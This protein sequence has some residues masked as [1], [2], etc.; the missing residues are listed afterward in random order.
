MPRHRQSPERRQLTVVYCDLVGSTALSNRIDAEELT[1]LIVAYRDAV[2]RCV[3][4]FDGMVAQYVG[5]GVLAYFGY[6]SAHENAAERAIRASLAM[7]AAVGQLH[8]ADGQPVHAHI[9]IATGSVVIGSLPRQDSV[10]V[11]VGHYANAAEEISAVGEAPNLAARLQALA[12]PD[13]IIVAPATRRLAGR[14]FR[15]R[16]LGDAHV[17]GFDEPVPTWEVT[18]ERTL[19]SRFHA[20]H[21]VG[22][23]PLIG[24]SREL[25]LL[26]ELWGTACSGR[27]QAVQLAG[28]P[29]LGKSRLAEAAVHK[30][31]EAAAIQLWYHCAPHSQSSAL[32]PLVRQLTLASRIDTADADHLKLQK[33]E[34]ILPDPAQRDTDTVPLLADLLAVDYTREYPD[35]QRMSARRRRSRLF[36]TVLLL[37]AA[38]AEQRPVVVVV[39]D[40]HWIDPSSMELIERAIDHIQT[41]PVMLIL[42]TRPGVR[43]PWEGRGNHREI[44][45]RPL[46][47]ASS[48]ALVRHLL[49]ARTVSRSVMERITDRADGVPLYI[50]GLT[51]HVIE[52]AEADGT[53]DPERPGGGE[54]DA[55][56]V[57]ASL[58]DSLM[59]RLDRIGATE[60]RVAQVA[61]VFGREFG[62]AML[63]GTSDVSRTHLDTAIDRLV[64]SGLVT[65]LSGRPAP[66]YSFRH[67]LIRDTA[68]SSLLRKERARLHDRAGRLLCDEFPEI[69]E[70]QPELI[71]HHF[72]RA[73]S[74]ET[75]ADFWLM[76]GRRSAKRSSFKEA[77]EQLQHVLSLLADQP[78]TPGTMQREMHAYIALGGA[79][80][81]YRGFSAP[82]SGEAYGT[83]LELARELDSTNEYF[84]ALSGAGSYHITR[85]EFDTC[86][87]L[88][89]ECL[90]RASRQSSALPFVIGRRLLGGTLFLTGEL[91]S[92]VEQ[93]KTAIALYDEHSSSFRETGMLYVQDHKSTALCYLALAY[94]VMGYL[95]R[96][97]QCARASLNHSRSLRDLHATNFSLTYLAAVHHFRR[98]APQ[99][100]ERARESM[101]MALEQEFGTWV[102]VSRMIYGEA[103]VRAGRFEEG[104]QAIMAG[105]QEHGTMEAVTYQPFG[106]SLLVKALLRVQRWD[107]AAGALEKAEAIV[108]RFGETWYL[109]ELWRLK[110]YVAQQ[111]GDRG[112]AEDLLRRAVDMA[113][114]QNARFWELRAA[115]ALGRLLLDDGEDEQAVGVVK[116]VHEWFREGLDTEHLQ[117]A[118]ALLAGMRA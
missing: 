94:T 31:L 13:M 45:L 19:I 30:S 28:E 116:P 15:Y 10:R 33:L 23:A 77:I 72:E 98:D 53:A 71:A 84:L 112:A 108:S 100:M 14:L 41:L 35:L 86:R 89:D 74:V 42:T 36:E 25:T 7:I 83:A 44:V 9:G 32:A 68:Y 69:S 113:R 57:P 85:A 52:T 115:T 87:S 99:T 29:G 79:Q 40:L 38:L 118:R 111:R 88:A 93:L 95:D 37:L 60:K 47:Y 61:S 97:L 18:G 8:T 34:S 17:K 66:V 96:G 50:E 11:D 27:G 67:V 12:G 73:G 6:P 92:A 56:S 5:D 103:L 48:I 4:H 82:E 102:G 106:I 55:F 109:P 39:E 63:A 105:T 104:L 64:S 114:R 110:G 20:L 26:Q 90:A 24:R 21:T 70:Q 81:G 3:T 22:R 62:Y 75:A 1:E 59:S 2:A 51:R 49:G 107:D 58:Q 80:A 76:A 65:R 78:R 46:E 101:E 91:E 117:T 16:F 43:M 54:L